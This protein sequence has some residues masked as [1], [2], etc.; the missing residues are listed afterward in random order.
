MPHT[1]VVLAKIASAGAGTAWTATDLDL[2]EV[3][4]L[5]ELAEAMLDAAAGGPVFA[6]LEE[7]DEYLAVI[8]LDSEA[9]DAKV[10]LSD[11]RV[12]TT[13]ELAERLFGEAVEPPVPADDPEEGTKADIEPAGDAGLLA[14]LGVPASELERL[15]RQQGNLPSD[16]AAILAEKVGAGDA[17][18]DLRG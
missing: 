6:L 5:D 4:T 15:C 11:A 9:D 8:R 14:D 2:S 12:V 3:G 13:S 16:I 1:A 18:D 17:L 10:F 7:D